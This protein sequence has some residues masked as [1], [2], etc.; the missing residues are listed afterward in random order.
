MLLEEILLHELFGKVL[1]PHFTGEDEPD[2]KDLQR[3]EGCDD[4]NPTVLLGHRQ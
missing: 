4:E 1:G 2:E 3:E